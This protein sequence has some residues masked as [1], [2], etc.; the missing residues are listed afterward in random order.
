MH[1]SICGGPPHHRM[2]GR[3]C[4]RVIPARSRAR[5]RSRKV[6]RSSSKPARLL[7]V[8]ALRM[9]AAPRGFRR[10]TAHAH[11][12][13]D[14]SPGPD[15]HGQRRRDGGRL[16][17]R[18]LRADG[19]LQPVAANRADAGRLLHRAR[20]AARARARRRRGQQPDHV[21]ADRA[22]QR[23]ADRG[24]HRGQRE[25]LR[26]PQTEQRTVVWTPEDDLVGW[27]LCSRPSEYRGYEL[28]LEATD[29][30]GSGTTSTVAITLGCDLI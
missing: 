21:P 1:A 6:S 26:L 15:Q 9:P 23:R 18:Q 8:L 29:S 19:D 30:A 4:S 20:D 24:D 13:G 2:I 27:P 22:P 16:R 5:A 3:T 17:R 10:R 25:R 7:H 28:V 12:D 11:R 14:R